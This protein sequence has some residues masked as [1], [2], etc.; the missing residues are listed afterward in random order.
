MDD[1]SHVW[2]SIRN[3]PT[4]ISRKF[5]EQ[6]GLDS[7]GNGVHE[8]L[9]KS[10]FILDQVKVMISRGDSMATIQDFIEWAEQRPTGE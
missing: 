6:M 5:L 3:R 2:D 4:T 9:L 1:A 7:I 8:S 10:Y